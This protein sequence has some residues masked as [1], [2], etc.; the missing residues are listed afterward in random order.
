VY[1]PAVQI[2][3]EA[4]LSPIQ[5]PGGHPSAGTVLIVED[6]EGLRE[7]VSRIL[8][9]AGYHVLAAGDA[10][11]AIALAAGYSGRLDL[12]LTD[13]R[14]PGLQGADL[15]GKLRK[16]DADLKVLFV[17]GDPSEMNL[18]DADTLLEKPFSPRELLQKIREVLHGER[19]QGA[20][21]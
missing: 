9:E 16:Q 13:L 10:T 14:L 6:E 17:S 21:K 2:A 8:R 5:Q 18:T 20:G 3:V 12:L 15:A 11:E 4:A 1:L 19:G 7:L